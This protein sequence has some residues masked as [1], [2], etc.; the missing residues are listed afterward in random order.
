MWS[1]PEGLCAH[2]ADLV[3]STEEVFRG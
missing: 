1:L 3:G 2:I